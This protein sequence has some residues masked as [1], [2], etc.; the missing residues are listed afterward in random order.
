[1]SVSR[2]F[3]LVWAIIII[4]PAIAFSKSEGSI[5]EVL[6]RVGSYFVG[7][8]LAMYGLGFFSKHTTEKGLLTGVVVGFAVVWAVAELTDI[9]WPWYCL[10]G[11]AANIAISLPV[12]LLLDGK[13][14]SWSPYSIPGQIQRYQR[15]NL[16]EKQDGWYLV[17]GKLDTMSYVLFGYFLV[18]LTLLYLFHAL[19]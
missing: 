5:L 16:P 18:C 14:A 9:A 11:A 12:S 2:W 10:I 19:I 1:M 7:A 13:Q 17:P 3:T 6:S 15:E 4:L 8:K